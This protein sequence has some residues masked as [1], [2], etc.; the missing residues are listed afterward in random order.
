[1]SSNFREGRVLSEGGIGGAVVG[2]AQQGREVDGGA[3]KRMVVPRRDSA[4]RLGESGVSL[5]AHEA[6]R[7]QRPVPGAP[8]ACSAGTSP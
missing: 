1:M 4:A 3:V 2:I 6:T 8:S 5:G 7:L